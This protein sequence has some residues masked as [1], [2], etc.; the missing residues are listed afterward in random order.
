MDRPAATPLAALARISETLSSTLHGPELVRTVVEHVGQLL[1]CDGT[2][3]CEF[4]EAT[5]ALIFRG[6]KGLPQQVLQTMR[7]APPLPRGR[8]T[9]SQLAQSSVPLLL[10]DLAI[11]GAMRSPFLPWFLQAGYRSMLGVPLMREGRTMGGLVVFRRAVDGFSPDDVDLLRAF[12]AECALA[13][14]HARVFAL[15]EERG[16]SLAASLAQQAATHEVVKVLAESRADSGPVFDAIARH[17]CELCDAQTSAVFGLD[18]GLIHVRAHHDWSPEALARFTALYPR[19]PDEPSIAAV[20]IAERRLVHVADIECE[21]SVPAASFVLLRALSYRAI[22]AVPML[23]DGEPIGAIGVMRSVPGAYTDGQIAL[24]RNFAD[25][26]VVAVETA[27]L[28]REVRER[29]AELARHRDR[30]EGELQL[31]RE[32]QLGMV[33]REFP[34]PTAAR[35]VG[36]HGVLEPAREIGGDLYDFYWHRDG[37]LWFVVADVSDKGAPAALYMARTKTLIRALTTLSADTQPASPARVLDRV[38]EELCGDNPHMMFVTIVLGLFDPLDGT[39]VVANAGHPQ[40]IG[41]GPAAPDGTVAVRPLPAPRG[42]PL[43]VSTRGRYVDARHALEHGACL[44]AYTDGIT[45]AANAAGELFG[46]ERLF[47]ALDAAA[48]AA[49]DGPSPRPLTDG[50]MASVRAFVAGAPQADDIALLALQ[51]R[52]PARSAS[53][54]VAQVHLRI[55]ARAEALARVAAAVDE[56]AASHAMPE[57]C[58]HDAQVVIDETLSN[59]VGHAYPGRTDDGAVGDDALPTIR[60]WLALDETTFTIEV[61]DDGPPFDPTRAAAPLPGGTLAERPIG[62]LGLHFIRSLCRSI[63]YARDAGCNRLTMRLDVGTGAPPAAL[64]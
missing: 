6:G 12:A 7:D 22:A 26:A 16:R 58:W 45:E 18:D 48:R 27:R 52:A 42:V 20:C 43:G 60:V 56:L 11:E 2:F 9:F 13:M 8:G 44:L 59:V 36:V 25:Q 21:P 35:P 34:A 14:T 10:P 5:D 17:A 4:D 47:A 38:N 64:S 39:L 46:D 55:P 62:G 1:D 3:L 57:R 19:R 51:R 54:A 63:E 24:L 31:A 15:L 41:V 30:M 29:N 33:P 28:F 49:A 53:G 50:V 37:R 32:I 61:E 40:P 23:R